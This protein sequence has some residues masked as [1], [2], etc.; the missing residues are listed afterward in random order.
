MK[1]LALLALTTLL[2]TGCTMNCVQGSGPVEE[3]TLEIASF[4]G[5]EV[6][7]SIQVTLE[8]GSEQKITVTAQPVLLDLLNTEVKSDVW[9]I[10]TSK[11]WSSDSEF[12][13]HIVTPSLINSIEVN[14]SADVGTADVFGSGNT[15]LSTSGSGTIT[16]AGIN[17][18]KL[19]LSISGSGAITVRGT[20]SELSATLSGSGDLIGEELTANEAVLKVSGSGSATITAISKLDAKVSGSGTVRYGGMPNVSSKVS[21]SGSVSPLQ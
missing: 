9:R 18:R 21:G 16:V 3:R 12:T 11:C 7:G 5:I 20:C 19:D 2:T 4:S 17:E 10:R 15:R 13:V 6:G 14:G 1:T 8:K